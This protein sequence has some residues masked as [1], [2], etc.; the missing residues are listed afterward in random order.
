[1]KSQVIWRLLDLPATQKYTRQE[2]IPQPTAYQPWTQSLGGDGLLDVR[3]ADRKERP[4]SFVGAIRNSLHEVDANLPLSR[5]EN[6]DRTG[7]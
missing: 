3:S 4:A 1:M 5:N 6:P 7:G 2:T